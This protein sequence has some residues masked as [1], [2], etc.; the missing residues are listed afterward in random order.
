M[1][2]KKRRLE[3]A[4]LSP[5]I[6]STQDR[7][8]NKFNFTP[9]NVHQEHAWETIKN[10]DITF[11]VGPAGCAKTLVATAYAAD[12]ILSKRQHKI[13]LTRPAVATEQ[14][15]FLPGTAD[16]KVLPYMM[17]ILDCIETLTGRDGQDRKRIT[18]AIEF[19]PIAYQRGRTFSHAVV[20][21]DECQ[22]MTYDQLKLVL[23]RIG[24]R[25]KMILTGDPFQSDLINSGFM[26]ILNKL[27]GVE[28]LG[29]VDLPMVSI[30][31][32]PIISRILDRIET[33]NA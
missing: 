31:R 12:S 11:L 15:G 6:P 28:G 7:T 18:E 8:V 32:H 30:V 23:T 21:A 2:K 20:I 14:L 27:R 4:N 13:I 29:V 9:W 3:P 1:S 19:S 33:R 25:T 17:P 5:A 22:N 26:N 16:E 24:K 10:N